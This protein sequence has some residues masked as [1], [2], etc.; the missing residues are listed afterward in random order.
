MFYIITNTRK[1]KI[2]SSMPISEDDLSN[3]LGDK[4]PFSNHHPD[5]VANSKVDRIL[6]RLRY[7]SK[8]AIYLQKTYTIAIE[9]EGG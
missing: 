4:T 8:M 9:E 7:I 3:L 5:Y 2:M 6:Y 1:D